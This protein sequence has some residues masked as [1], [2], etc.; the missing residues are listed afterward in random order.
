MAQ[1]PPAVPSRDSRGR[2]SHR[3]AT[4][5]VMKSK[6]PEN[7]LL[8]AYLDGE[9]TAS[10]QAD[11][12]Q[13]LAQSA[14]ARQLVDELR[15]L[16]ATL[17]SLPAHKLEEDLSQ[18]VLQ[19]AG[20]RMLSVPREPAESAD[21]SGAEAAGETPFW[22]AVL[23]RAVSRRNL[24]WSAVAVAA[25]ILLMVMNPELPREERESRE[26]HVAMAPEAEAPAPAK[27][28]FIGAAE[29]AKE[30]MS[31]RH[32]MEA[33][34]DGGGAVDSPTAGR[35]AEIAKT[36]PLA[37]A[38]AA[39]KDE[40]GPAA[41]E[42]PFARGAA[43]ERGR[44]AR[45]PLT[46]GIPSP[47]KLPAAAE[48]PGAAALPAAVAGQM[49]APGEMGGEGVGGFKF[50]QRQLGTFGGAGSVPVVVGK[51]SEEPVVVLCE[52]TPEA[53]RDGA[54]ERIVNL[55]ATVRQDKKASAGGERSVEVELTQAQLDGVLDSLKKQPQLFP[56][57]LTGVVSPD[58]GIE[59]KADQLRMPGKG[60]VQAQ[61]TL[62][63]QTTQAMEFPEGQ[64]AL[65]KAPLKTPG[66]AQVT[67][68]PGSGAVRSAYGPAVQ[69]Q[70][71]PGGAGWG[72]GRAGGGG[73]GQPGPAPGVRQGDFRM[74]RVSPVER[75][76]GPGGQQAGPTGQPV[77]PAGQPAGPTAIQQRVQSG[78][79]QNMADQAQTE[80]VNAAERGKEESQPPPAS[81][82]GFGG[83]GGMKAGA[84]RYSDNGVRGVPRKAMKFKAQAPAVQQA[85][86]LDYLAG[87]LD[88]GEV[89]LRVLF[90]LRQL[91]DTGPAEATIVA[92]D[93]A[94]KAD[95][96]KAAA[97][98]AESKPAAESA[99]PPAAPA[100]PPGPMPA[101]R[102]SK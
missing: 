78:P 49:K 12:E 38:L 7:E 29:D 35:A 72:S 92:K 32:A 89:R 45:A 31:R 95:A 41:G 39:S 24:A 73:M 62:R 68:E 53:V 47:A 60:G 86:A 48:A 23:R 57:V 37:K 27:P 63:E 14:A 10:E 74:Q 6:V 3:G 9:L 91:P 75:Q 79:V 65:E 28:S 43:L 26:K 22:R 76:A 44:S 50:G 83:M 51:R 18:E 2:L 80:R 77:A 70:A 102:D 64:K 54:F 40:P 42:R 67:R 99:V 98:A 81:P 69:Q 101:R 56:L 58:D 52:L 93:H 59:H 1:P 36:A 19:I 11:V 8:S 4:G 34:P 82:G 84:E 61:G 46:A 85:P 71:M 97:K 17:Q 87:Q 30:A 66:A 94:E 88:R 20:R 21:P 25:A 16:S 5:S 13:L 55:G 15:A 90:V 96:A 33:K 100:N